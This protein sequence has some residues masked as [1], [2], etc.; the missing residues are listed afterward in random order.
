M[1]KLGIVV[2]AEHVKS[3]WYSSSPNPYVRVLHAFIFAD[4]D[5]T[6]QLQNTEIVYW[7]IVSNEHEK[8]KKYSCVRI[9]TM[10]I[11]KETRQILE[12]VSQMPLAFVSF[13]QM[14]KGNP[15][16]KQFQCSIGATTR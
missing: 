8:A 12:F 16:L 4:F 1:I 14:G 10:I 6:I 9:D 5:A 13:T 15:L 7:T 2:Y 3:K 11:N